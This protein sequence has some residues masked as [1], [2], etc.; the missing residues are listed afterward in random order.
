MRTQ[1]VT[2]DI[3]DSLGM[4]EAYG[5]LSA[6]VTEGGPAEEAGIAAGFLGR[7]PSLR[8][9]RPSRRLTTSLTG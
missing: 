5:A 4:S 6:G 1:T 9:I 8:P 2:E 7:T 3:A